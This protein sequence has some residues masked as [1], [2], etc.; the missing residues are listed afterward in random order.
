MIRSIMFVAILI[1]G[2]VLVQEAHAY[3]VRPDKLIVIL[4]EE[5]KVNLHL[6]NEEG[7]GSLWQGDEL[8][9]QTPKTLRF[10]IVCYSDGSG[11]L[12]IFRD[13]QN[14]RNVTEVLQYLS[15]QARSI[16]TNFLVNTRGKV[17]RQKE[18]ELYG[19]QITTDP[20]GHTW[21]F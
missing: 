18:E 5:I 19:P 21:Y 8:D 13:S 15:P 9:L 2:Q 20:S 17:C 16:F 1:V 4:E 3:D 11:A 10:K 6:P 14:I 7:R 12:S